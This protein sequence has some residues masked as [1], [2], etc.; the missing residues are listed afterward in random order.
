MNASTRLSFHLERAVRSGNG[1]A[2]GGVRG[3]GAWGSCWQQGWSNGGR[4]L[5]EQSKHAFLGGP[6]ESQHLWQEVT[7]S[8]S[9]VDI[10]ARVLQAR[11]DQ[12]SSFSITV[13]HP[14][15]L[16]QS[17]AHPL[18]ASART[19][20]RGLPGRGW[21]GCGP[22]S[23][24]CCP[25]RGPCQVSNSI[26]QLFLL[27]EPNISSLHPSRVLPGRLLGSKKTPGGPVRLT[28]L[29]RWGQDAERSS[30]HL[31]PTSQQAA[32]RKEGSAAGGSG[33]GGGNCRQNSGRGR[34]ER[35]TGEPGDLGSSS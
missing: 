10:N 7:N 26:S 9:T 24:A 2:D 28:R 35:W 16:P 5:Q 30:S 34:G 17:P 4:R 14:S 19:P 33:Q 31:T 22:A 13:G 32:S 6:Q 12:C 29:G 27:G 15:Y 23:P 3:R 18:L 25:G 20:V 1:E 8:S 21:P 11:H